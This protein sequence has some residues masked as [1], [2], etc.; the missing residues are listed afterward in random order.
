MSNYLAIST[1]TAALYTL[2]TEA[3]HVVPGAQVTTTRPDGAAPGTRSP[4]INIF[5]YQV[6][7]NGAFR[8]ADLPTRRANGDTV[9]VP[10]AALDLNY[11]LSFY[12]NES[13][14]EP[15]RLLG[16][17]VRSLHAHPVLSRQLV[18]QALN[19]TAP[20][21]APPL[22][23]PPN[24]SDL[25]DQIELV[26]LMPVSLSLEELSKLWSVFFQVP[27][28]LS[29][30]YKAGVVLIEGKET[31]KPSQPVRARNVYTVTFRAP[32]IERVVS[33]AG[34]DQPIVSGSTLLIQGR[35][36]QG[37]TTRVLLNGADRVPTN[38]TNSQVTLPLPADVSAG[39]QALQV[40]HYAEL[41]TPPAPHRGV[42]SNV[43]AFVLRPSLS[44]ITATSS[45]VSFAVSPPVHA[46]QRVVLLL[47]EFAVAAPAAYTFVP[48]PPAAD[49]GN[50]SIGISGVKPSTY[51]VR[52]QVDGAESPLDFDDNT[53]QYTGPKVVIP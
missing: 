30:A 8:N 51:L 24:S 31:A 15:Q 46:G 34:P 7:P 17:A 20:F 36:L 41:G 2:L 3:A 42:Q 14:F 26:R 38:V 12:G 18:Q 25:A 16:S 52:L 5:L 19:D 47:N 13:V 29:I 48:P 28:A 53:N 45:V 33:Q 27:Y 23:T 39:V 21:N 9:Q 22:N 1:V 6:E 50:L 49:T 44:A 35:Q 32:V 37:D 43:A 11:L 4:E 40:I 10:R